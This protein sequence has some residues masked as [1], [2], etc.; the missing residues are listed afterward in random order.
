MQ[1]TLRKWKNCTSY[2][3]VCSRLDDII[4]LM[5][6]MN[7]IKEFKGD[8]ECWKTEKSLNEEERTEMMMFHNFRWRWHASMR[9]NGMRKWGKEHGRWKI[10]Q[11]WKMA[12][13]GKLRT[14]GWT[15]QSAGGL[16]RKQET[17]LDSAESFYEGHMLFPKTSPL[18]E[19][20]D[21]SA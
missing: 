18:W 14:G 21:A 11:F 19:T 1:G 10:K 17:T 13:E 2:P 12:E 8:T 20:S 9:A 7:G 4:Q 3:T 16:R 6:M 15:A 5:G